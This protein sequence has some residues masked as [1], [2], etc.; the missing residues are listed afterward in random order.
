[1]DLGAQLRSCAG[2]WRGCPPATGAALDQLR[3]GAPI[4]LPDEYVSLLAISNGGEG[5]LGINPGWVS[6]WPAEHILECNADYKVAEFA[7]GLF[8]FGSNGGG[9]L[10]AFDAR[11]G[12]PHSVVI[13]PL[14]PLELARAV[15]VAP[16]FR[17]FVSA[18]GTPSP[19]V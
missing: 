10:L 17:S 16:D 9:E 15:P 14:I 13:V 3:S 5:D 6:F 8:A 11:S 2:V 18:V 12:P 19:A 1:M 7:P 4:S